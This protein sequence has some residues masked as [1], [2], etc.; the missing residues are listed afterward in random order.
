MTLLAESLRPAP[1]VA[2]VGPLFMDK[3]NEAGQEEVNSFSRSPLVS[4]GAE[5]LTLP[6]R[7]PA[8]PY[9][10]RLIL[11]LTVT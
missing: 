10:P 4:A 2:A 3:R 9:W 7:I 5:S 1:E 8:A 6:A 11:T